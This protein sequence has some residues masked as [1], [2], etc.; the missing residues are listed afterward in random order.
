VPLLISLV[1][2]E[3]YIYIDRLRLWMASFRVQARN[4]A[5]RRTYASG[6]ELVGSLQRPVELQRADAAGVYAEWC[7]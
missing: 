7:S 4:G 2:P 6:A 1:T 3:V 5:R